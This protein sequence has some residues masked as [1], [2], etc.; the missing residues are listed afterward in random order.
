MSEAVQLRT[1]HS[2]AGREG[3][4]LGCAKV[5]AA[6][7]NKTGEVEEP[8]PQRSSAGAPC[9]LLLSSCAL[10]RCPC[11]PSAHHA[12]RE[13]LVSYL[14][15]HLR[16][17]MAQLDLP[18]SEG[19]PRSLEAVIGKTHKPH[20]GG[21]SGWGKDSR[22]WHFRGLVFYPEVVDCSLVFSGGFLCKAGHF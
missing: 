4:L 13:F 2:E 21:G 15:F 11:S 20:V 9:P 14:R 18:S 6:Q 8:G 17:F 7:M 1:A 3:L 22:G 10:P 5:Q 16:A 12:L 19:E